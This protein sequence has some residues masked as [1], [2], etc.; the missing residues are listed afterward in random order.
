[1]KDGKRGFFVL[2]VA[3]IILAMTQTYVTTTD[4]VVRMFGFISTYVVIV[5]LAIY[6][7][8]IWKRIKVINYLGIGITAIGYVYSVVEVFSKYPHFSIELGIMIY[9]LS[10]I[11]F[12]VSIFMPDTAKLE[13]NE[14]EAQTTTIQSDGKVVEKEEVIDHSNDVA[15]GTYISG[16]PKRPELS[17]KICLLGYDNDKFLLFITNGDN[18]EKYEISYGI[19]TDI[20]SRQRVV[21]EQNDVVNEDTTQDRQKLANEVISIYGKEIAEAIVSN[22]K[23]SGGA[24]SYNDLFELNLSFKIA[25]EIRKLIINVDSD[26]TLFINKFNSVDKSNTTPFV[27]SGVTNN[28][29]IQSDEVPVI[30]VTKIAQTEEVNKAMQEENK[31]EDFNSLNSAPSNDVDLLDEEESEKVEELI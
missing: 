26:P 28:E 19:V 1:M 27:T 23:T 22:N 7:V 18:V 13:I 29:V 6:G 30:D 31:Q 5:G 15:Y 14:A 8:G 10:L 17:K 3:F 25:D 24:V 12:I 4:E 20:S 21:M 2:V 9:L 16:I 11:A